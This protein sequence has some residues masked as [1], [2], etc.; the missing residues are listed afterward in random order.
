MR[1]IKT[2]LAMTGFVACLTMSL[3]AWANMSYTPFIHE[4]VQ[5]GADVEVTVNVFDEIEGVAPTGDTLP[6]MS[7]AYTLGW[8][9]YPSGSV[10][11]EDRVFDPQEAVEISEY[12]C[13]YWDYY[14]SD[15]WDGALDCDGDG[16]FECSGF[17][18]VAY[19]YTVTEHCPEYLNEDVDGSP[20][21]YMKSDPP[22]DLFFED[23]DLGYSNWTDVIEDVGD[24]CD[25]EWDT[26]DPGDTDT[27]DT[28]EDT[29]EDDTGTNEGDPAEEGADSGCS[30]SRVGSPQSLGLIFPLAQLLS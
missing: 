12:E 28:D 19:R 22:C 2:I 26:D 6:D 9:G 11:F 3:S 20:L 30:A 10:L 17:C 8:Y 15:K 25:D 18:A 24:L 13:Q 27:T 23:E 4:I 29:G 7:A 16:V 21:Y 1:R 14:G 5:D